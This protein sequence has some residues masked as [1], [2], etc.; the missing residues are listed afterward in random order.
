MHISF[1]TRILKPCAILVLIFSLLCHAG[2]SAISSEAVS[3]REYII[4][5]GDQLLIT[6]AGYEKELTAFVV[7]RPD[8]MIT[9]PIVGDIEAAGLTVAQLSKEISRRLSELRYYKDPQVTV[10]LRQIIQERIFIFGAVLDPGQK[11]FPSSVNIFQALA[12]A[13]GHMANADLVNAR[14]IKKNKEIIPVDLDKLLKDYVIGQDKSGA[15]ILYDKLLLEDGDVLIIPS[16]IKD[17][18]VNIIGN[19]KEPGLFTVR[20]S[21]SVIE[22]LGLAGG[23]MENTAD[24][25]RVK[26]IRSNGD[27]ISVDVLQ[28]LN[29]QNSGSTSGNFSQELVHPGD[30]VYVPEKGRVRVIGNVINQGQFAVSGEI[31][32]FEVLAL[33]G[34]KEG[35][36]L[37]KLKIIRSDGKQEIINASEIWKNP[38]IYVDERMGSGDTLVVPPKRFRMNWS[39]ISAVVMIFSTLYAVFK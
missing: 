39:A 6:V 5:A 35:A 22:A 2:L 21:F 29:Q 16:A 13:G 28:F 1:S 17:E 31:S 18:Q 36:D 4:N 10:Q 38:E 25:K 34:F 23:Y 9:Y 20:S 19:V 27:F 7:V 33:A 3:R 26:I 37:K 30:T 12:A 24:L 15:D 14:I 32:L 8:G 11:S